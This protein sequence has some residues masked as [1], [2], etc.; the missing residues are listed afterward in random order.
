MSKLIKTETPKNR[1]QVKKNNKE[2]LIVIKNDGKSF[3][4]ASFTLV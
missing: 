3:N 2:A 1:T 4:L